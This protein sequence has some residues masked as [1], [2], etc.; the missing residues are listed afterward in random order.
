MCGIAGFTAPGRGARQV[1]AAMNRALAHRGPDG[2][3]LFVDGRIAFAHTRLAIIDPAGGAQPRVDRETGDALVFN[4]EIYG[5]RALADEL[6]RSG[7]QLRDRSDTEVLFQLIRRLGV[8]RA[9]ARVD[10][11]FAFAYR[12]GS[13]GTLYL[14]RDRFGEKPLYYGLAGGALIF[15]SEAPAILAHPAFRGAALD[16]EA[17]YRFLFFEYLPGNASGWAGIEKLE[18]ATILCFH[19]GG[20]V[21]E[22]WWRP[23]V[24]RRD[25]R[26]VG[27]GEAVERLDALL[28]DS[29]RRRVV[30][31]VPVGVF[32]SGG[33][34]SSLLTALAAEAS[35][36]L[37]A[38]SVR[39]PGAGFDET[40][41]AQAVARQLGVRHEIVELGEP[42]LLDAIDAVT[43]GL[44][45]PL[46]DASLLPT[47]LL[48]RAARRRMRVALGGD[49]ADELFAGYPNFPVQRWAAAMRLLPQG[50]GRLCRRLVA[51]LPAGEHYMNRL[52]LLSQLSQ[53]FG[54]ATHRQSFLWMAPIEP[55]AMA[56]LWRT[57]ALPE[58]GAEAAFRAIDGHAADAAR[59]SQIDR[60]LHL[61]LLTYLPE[62]ILAKT[63][64]ASMMNG[65]EVRAPFL[66][67]DF[68]EYAAALPKTLKLDGGTTKYVLKRLA[69]RYLPQWVVERR[70][71]GFAVP[72]G[73]LIR[74]LYRERCRDMLLSRQNPVADWFEHS[75]IES[76]IDEH[77][78]GGRDHGKK[79][80]ALYVLFAVAGGARPPASLAA[81]A[82]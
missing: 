51:A 70:K 22:R 5:Y 12:D 50:L 20:I 46:A 79:L 30:A 38:F 67:R 81:A 18:P 40:P 58:A 34:D 42:D 14:A 4:G 19:K 65:L 60:L 53:G 24:A 52:F 1:L 23:Q 41:Q 13:T 55:N 56:R 64:R 15:A 31:D 17:A 47:W 28:R 10:G 75:A 78:S 7:V 62:D 36:D 26:G 49:G 80:W 25:R 82:D 29:V 73:R 76:L 44:G 61:F 66:D 37:T 35:S 21:R 71:H 57:S 48:C 32:L 27:E 11:M 77:E 43:A 54:A 74:T 16:R 59:L 8:A 72:I 6:S 33:L 3:G 45:E 2:S 68:A 63:D 69:G 9:V 39:V